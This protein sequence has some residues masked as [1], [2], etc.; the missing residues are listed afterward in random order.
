M[1]KLL[2]R[3]WSIFVLAACLIP[4]VSHAGF[5]I[6]NGRL[7]DDNGTPFVM[8]GI[9]YPFAWFTSRYPVQT[10]QD[11]D[12]MAATGA[13]TVRIV[14]GTGG[15][16]LR[17]TGPQIAQLIEWAKE[18]EMI[19]VL[20]V[21]DSTGWPD[22]GTAVHISNAVQFWTSADIRAAINGQEDFVI[23]N[24]ANEPFGNNNVAPYVADTISAIQT[25]RSAG[26]THN[27]MVD[28]PNWGQDWSGTMRTAAQQIWNADPAR[29]LTFSV[30]MYE[31]YQDAT[32]IS[33][34]MQAFQTA[35]LPLVVGEF[36]VQNNG[37]PV[38]EHAVMAQA[39]Q[40]GL[41]YIG[42]SWSG[43]GGCCT[44]LDIVTNFGTSL[45]P[46]GSTLINDPNGI[47][48][49]SQP[50]TVFGGTPSNNLTVSSTSIS[51]GAGAANSLITVTSNV[52]WS[53]TD[54][55]SWLTTSPTAG[56]NNGSFTV[57]ATG[58]T[59]AAS[60]SGTITV[61]GGGVQRTISVTQAGT[62]QQQPPAVPSGLS[63][64]AGNAQV[65]L[66]WSASAGATSYN[67]KR[68]TTSGGP[69]TTVASNVTATSFTN[70]G[71]TNGTAYFYVVSAVNAN[72]E[73]ANSSQASATP[74][75]GGT[76]NGGVT[77]SRVVG[78]SG[79]WFNELQVLVS[80]TSPITAMTV[81]IVVQRTA[82]VNYSG[83]YNTVG[84]QV[85]QTNSS[86]AAA[87]TYTYTLASGQTLGPAN[88]RQFVAQA[89]GSGTAH[90]TSGDT[91]TVT[92]TT[93]GV[94]RTQTGTF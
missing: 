39:Q 82:G 63:A 23:V 7:M 49:T 38:D 21:H 91:Y 9:N 76:G 3:G 16:Y 58:T 34:Y 22:A 72:G 71:L 36:G 6:Q 54:N 68:S 15:Q 87:I 26:I 86:T 30:H 47:R 31:V 77:V 27:I 52:T 94:Q 73:S 13:N 57:S 29:N 81:T 60:R 10:E 56:S 35:G 12:N 37:Q 89:G 62:T 25:M 93:G 32:T 50:A 67:V 43:N 48:A 61:S 40:R 1:N 45:T 84:G 5:F 74:Q 88:N 90:P 33:N 75:Q 11:F 20:E 83:M 24:I 80:N 65:A 44:L 53:V 79:P 41:G 4:A 66:S 46:W 19:V 8:R 2:Q 55:A 70:T 92:Y 78:T 51:F 42:W 17:S 64:T 18:R 28:A 14:L 59:A 85:Q 69:Y